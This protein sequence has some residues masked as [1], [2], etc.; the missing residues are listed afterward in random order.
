MATAEEG[1]ASHLTLSTWSPFLPCRCRILSERLGGLE[2]GCH[3][4]EIGEVAAGL[5]GVSA[6]GEHVVDLVLQAPERGGDPG[7]GR[8]CGFA[9]DAR[10]AEQS[11]R[12]EFWSLVAALSWVQA[13]VSGHGQK[14]AAGMLGRVDRSSADRQALCGILFVLHTGVWDQLHPALLMKLQSAKK[15]DWS[16]AVIDPMTSV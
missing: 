13:A 7:L 15:L 12:G 14:S 4:A 3:D 11:V 6:W 1:G 16:R 10:A 9:V 5:G 2:D 8:V